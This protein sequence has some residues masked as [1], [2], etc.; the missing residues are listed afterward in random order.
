MD[1]ER[2]D[3]GIVGEDGGGAVAVVHVGINDHG[4]ADGAIG[5]HFAD[6][7][8]YIVDRAET[9]AMSGVGVME[10]AADVAAEAIKGG[11]LRG[12]DGTPGGEPEG[13]DEF[14]R[15]RELRASSNRFE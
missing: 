13:V 11:G 8:G 15:V 4:F 10:A 2:K 7:N 3:G 1:G 6:G 9:L 14:R 12:E 5:L